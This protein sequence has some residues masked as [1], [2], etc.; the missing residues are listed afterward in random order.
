MRDVNSYEWKDKR[1]GKDRGEKQ[2]TI[3]LIDMSSDQLQY[4]YNICKEML[5]NSDPKLPGRM[6][7][8]NNL[9]IQK[10]NCLAE[11]CLRWFMSLQDKDGNYSYP[12]AEVVM[13]ELRGWAKSFQAD[14]KTMLKEFLEI[15]AEYRNV[16]VNTLETACRDALG[17]FDHSKISLSFIYNLGL[18]LTQEELNSID[19]DIKSV[20][21]N[22]D[23]FTLQMK[24]NRHVKIPLGIHEADIKINPKG[25]TLAEFK[26]MINMKHSKGYRMVKYSNL[27]TSQLVTLSTKVLY[28][29]EEKVKFQIKGWKERMS[30][31]EEVAKVKGY[32]LV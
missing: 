17:A 8:I 9:D 20:G 28:A 6:I 27:S 3:K 22:P 14:D 12:S 2:I 23:D 1:S 29:L 13:N 4:C 5:Y 10:E 15:P 21:Q 11:R 7:V 19:D 30:Q 25:L 26:D 16:R 31:I 24:I 32:K 18:Y